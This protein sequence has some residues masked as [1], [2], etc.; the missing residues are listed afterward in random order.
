MRIFGSRT[1]PHEEMT[2]FLNAD[3]KAASAYDM[4]VYKIVD[5]AMGSN[6]GTK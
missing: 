5:M 2:P 4:E 6:S 3:A 1:H